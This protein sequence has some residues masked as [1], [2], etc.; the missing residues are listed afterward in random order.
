MRKI[1]AI[2]DFWDANSPYLSK[3]IF[4]IPSINNRKV[5][6]E[7]G[8]QDL[9]WQIQNQGLFFE[10]KLNANRTNAYFHWFYFD[11]KKLKIDLDLA[12][13]L[14]AFAKNYDKNKSK[15]IYLST[16]Y[17]VLNQKMKKELSCFKLADFAGKNEQELIR[18]AKQNKNVV[19]VSDLT[20]YPYNEGFFLI[21]KGKM[22]ENGIKNIIPGKYWFLVNEKNK[23]GLKPIILTLLDNNLVKEDISNIEFAFNLNPLIVNSKI[24]RSTDGK[25][26][27]TN[28]TFIHS[29]HGAIAHIF[30]EN[31]PAVCKKLVRLIDESKTKLTP[32]LSAF[33]KEQSKS[34][35]SIPNIKSEDVRN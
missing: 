23:S 24:I 7:I 27:G 21:Y 18:E 33:L 26:L 10:G 25:I 15:G 14:E 3:A 28:E 2:R 34:I 22:L 35:I 1:I 16:E 4:D 30:E 20:N 11:P 32:E 6:L 17:A 13:Q 5:K 19:L 31:I 9:S 8:Y 29:W 12:P